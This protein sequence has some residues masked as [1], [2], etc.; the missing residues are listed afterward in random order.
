M[1]DQSYQT[2][3]NY[4]TVILRLAPKLAAKFDFWSKSHFH[5][6]CVS[7]RFSN[8]T[9]FDANHFFFLQGGGGGGGPE[10]LEGGAT[11][12]RDPRKKS[13]KQD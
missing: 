2:K 11:R 3:T 9:Y 7:A 8:K 4:V 12:M 5:S 13:F 6:K 10:G 1:N